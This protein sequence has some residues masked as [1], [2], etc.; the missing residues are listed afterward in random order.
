M[1]VTSELPVWE[2]RDDGTTSAR[3]FGACSCCRSRIADFVLGVC[4]MKPVR[5]A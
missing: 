1:Q 2:T 4:S 5:R 3:M